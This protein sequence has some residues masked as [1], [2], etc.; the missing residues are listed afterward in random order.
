ME[1]KLHPLLLYGF[2]SFPVLSNTALG[3]LFSLLISLHQRPE[4][5]KKMMIFCG[6]TPVKYYPH[7]TTVADGHV[8]IA[9]AIKRHPCQGIMNRVNR[10]KNG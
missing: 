4:R 2:L 7:D 9:V 6:L 5:E 8:A 1:N 3:L 10:N